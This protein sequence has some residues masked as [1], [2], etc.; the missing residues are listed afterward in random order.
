MG[1]G[2]RCVRLTTL[3]PSCA[4]VTKSGNL[5]FLEPS[6]TV[7][8]GNWTALP[9]KYYILCFSWIIKYVII[10]DARC[11][12]EDS[13]LCLPTLYQLKYYLATYEVSFH[14][15]SAGCN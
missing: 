1:R 3:A 4:V 7:Q 12:H 8:A 11:K 2:G 14:L 5:N 9:F 15:K 10:I 6:E 13:K